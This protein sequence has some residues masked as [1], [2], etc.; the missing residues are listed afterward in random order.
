MNATNATWRT[1]G[2][3]CRELDWSPRRLLYELG[4]G[5]PYRTIPPGHKIDWSDPSI[6]L[7]VP[8][9][10]VTFH[11]YDEEEAKECEARNKPGDIL[12]LIYTGY[13]KTVGIEVAAPA[14]IEPAD[15]TGQWAYAATRRLRDERKIPK[16]AK[17]ADVA[18]L[19]EKE[20]PKPATAGGL[21]RALKASYLE[22][23]LKPWGIWPL[24]SLK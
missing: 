8:A 10:E 11:F 2:A 12:V 7:D 13:D 5:W 21:G 15:P 22:N 20:A 14:D 16:G 1:L 17:Q 4:Q 18:R 9:S 6:R 3:I 24:G 19:L 23:Q